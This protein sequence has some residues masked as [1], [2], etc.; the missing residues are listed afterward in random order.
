MQTHLSCWQDKSS[1]HRLLFIIIVLFFTSV[2]V[3][4]KAYYLLS[5]VGSC[6]QK[7]ELSVIFQYNRVIAV[8]PSFTMPYSLRYLQRL[9]IGKRGR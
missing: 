9:R 8:H 1:L 5:P 6:Q 4:A 7:R 3:A 2:V